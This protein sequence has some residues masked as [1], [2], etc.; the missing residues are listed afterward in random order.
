[1]KPIKRTAR[2][3]TLA[4]AAALAALAITALPALATRTVRIDSRVGISQKFP[5]FHGRV[6]AD[7]RPC[8]KD[9]V[10]KLFR[11]RRHRPDKLLGR[12]RT[13][14]H[15]RWVVRVKRLHSG[16]YRAKLKARRDGTA[17]TVYVCKRARS[18]VVPVD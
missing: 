18:S 13:N 7:R 4:A 12:D 11:V 6:H 10:V 3:A 17:G 14:R 8:V 1:M 2:I 15:G 5:A 9:R 16:A